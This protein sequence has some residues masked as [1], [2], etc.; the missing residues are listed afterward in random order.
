MT[1]EMLGTM[2]KCISRRNNW[3]SKAETKDLQTSEAFEA[4]GFFEAKQ[5]R[6]VTA[7]M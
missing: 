1:C 3:K 7:I 5:S 2:K 4:F 6:I